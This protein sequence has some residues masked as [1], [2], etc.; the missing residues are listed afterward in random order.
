MQAEVQQY[1][2]ELSQK[3]AIIVG[4]KVDLM[5]GGS[6]R[7]LGELRAATGMPVHLVSA[8]HGHGMND[9][10]KALSGLLSHYDIDY[11]A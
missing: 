5:E 7:L 6:S 3:Q 8:K 11:K 2:S 4:N 10:R 1:S 9:L